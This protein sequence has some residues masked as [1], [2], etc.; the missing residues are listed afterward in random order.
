MQIELKHLLASVS[1]PNYGF[2]WVEVDD[3]IYV[4]DRDLSSNTPMREVICNLLSLIKISFVENNA[5]IIKN[6]SSD[7]SEVQARIKDKLYDD[8]TKSFTRR[9]KLIPRHLELIENMYSELDFSK[10]D[11]KK[12]NYIKKEYQQLACN[13]S[14]KILNI[15]R[16]NKGIVESPYPLQDAD[17]SVKTV[18]ALE[19]L[20]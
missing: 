19:I 7:M 1:Y 10:L 16:I 17:F 13:Y 2:S 6:L 14:A 18:K 15:T 3:G 11:S 9:S 8:K 20:K 12:S 5:K 4:W